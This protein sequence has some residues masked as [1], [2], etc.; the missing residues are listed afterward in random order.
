MMSFVV[1]KAIAGESV[2][3]VID[4][5][6]MLFKGKAAMNERR[7]GRLI[8]LFETTLV[9]ISTISANPKFVQL[10]VD[11]AE[12][13]AKINRPPPKILVTTQTI[14]MAAPSD[15][16]LLLAQ[17][18]LENSSAKELRALAGHELG[19]ISRGDHLNFDR[20]PNHMQ[21]FAA[22][23][24]GVELS[25]EPAAMISW[26]ER[27]A[28]ESPDSAR[29]TLIYPSVSSRIEGILRVGKQ[30]ILPVNPLESTPHQSGRS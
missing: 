22:D 13:A 30:E 10:E 24:I 4:A 26:L 1:F 23:R 2:K 5:G 17:A 8:K 6:V 19:H 21:E 27:L 7:V 9:D 11:I 14:G 12:M 16:I 20:P 28:R 15:K 3:M 25:G 18:E 29:E